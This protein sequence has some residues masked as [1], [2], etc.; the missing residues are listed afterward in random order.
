M[1]K[2]TV[3]KTKKRPVKKATSKRTGKKVVTKKPTT[4][5]R[6]PSAT[7]M[8]FN[9]NKFN[10]IIRTLLF[11]IILF[12]INL[13]LYSVTAVEFWNNLFFLLMVVFGFVSI[14]LLIVFLIYAFSRILKR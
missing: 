9:Q 8:R 4:I 13:V 14:A 2:K 7:P 11:F 5:K 3:R 12:V 10:T 1:A 6:N